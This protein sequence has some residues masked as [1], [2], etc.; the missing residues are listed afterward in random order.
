MLIFFVMA[1]VWLSFQGLEKKIEL[2]RYTR[3][4]I[5]V[6]PATVGSCLFP[7]EMLLSDSDQCGIELHNIRFKSQSVVAIWL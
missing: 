2:A 4:S 3:M 5:L 1:E 7:W 6:Q